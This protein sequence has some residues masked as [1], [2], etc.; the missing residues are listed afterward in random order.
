MVAAIRLSSEVILPLF[1]CLVRVILRR[2]SAFS[3]TDFVHPIWVCRIPNG[4]GAWRNILLMLS[5]F[6]V[7]IL[8]AHAGSDHYGLFSHPR[9]MLS[10][11]SR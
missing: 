6:T 3:Y 11:N 2:I 7:L 10:L 5:A 4:L 9:V 1:T 8:S